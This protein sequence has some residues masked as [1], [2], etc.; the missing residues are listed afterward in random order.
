M[1]T[2][3]KSKPFLLRYDILSFIILYGILTPIIYNLIDI[4]FLYLKFI[5]VI[6]FFF[7]CIFYLIT[8]TNPKYKARNRYDQVK[9]IKLATHVKFV[10]KNKL[11]GEEVD[12]L[13]LKNLKIKLDN[14][15]TRR[16]VYFYRHKLRYYWKKEDKKFVKIKPFLK[17]KISNLIENKSKLYLD[18]VEE[19]LV[20][21]NNLVF[22]LPNFG[23][24]YKEQIMNPLNFFQLFSVALW[25]FD[26]N[27]YHPLM[28]LFLLLI[29]NST[30]CMQ[31]ISTILNLRSLQTKP[32]YVTIKCHETG[33]FK[34]ISSEN[35]KPGDIVVVKRSA[36]L[37]AVDNKYQSE[38]NLLN[39]LKKIV[40]FGSKLPPNLLLKFVPKAAEQKEIVNSSDLLILKGSVAVD[41]SILTGE[42][43]PQIKDPINQLFYNET[44]DKK[45]FK[46][47]II[48]AGTDIVQITPDKKNEEVLAK[49]LNTGFT[50]TKGKLARTVLFGEKTNTP[51]QYEAYLL[52]FI[53][54]IVSVFSSVYVLIQGLAEEDRN[55]DKLFIR[56]I[57]IVTSVVPP[58]LPMIMTMA[59]NNSLLYLKKKRIFCTE[60]HRINLAGKITTCV[61]DKTGT[62]TEEQLILKGVSLISNDGNSLKM[63]EDLRNNKFERF[64]DISMILGGCHSIVEINKKDVGDPVEMLFFENSDFKFNYSNK[65]TF[66][67]KNPNKYLKIRKTFYFNSTLKRM[68]SIIKVKEFDTKQEDYLVVKGAPEVIGDLLLNKPKNYDKFYFE[69]ANSGYRLLSLAMRPLKKNELNCDVRSEIEKDLIFAGFLVLTNDLKKDTKFYIENIVESGRDI[70]ILT[71]DHL[72]TSIQTYRSLEVSKKECLIITKKGENLIFTKIDGK[73][74]V[75]KNLDDYDLTVTGKYL[76]ELILEKPNLLKKLKVIARVNPKQKE[77]FIGKLKENEK[78]L[79]CGDGTNDVGALKKADVGIALVGKKPE[80]T[81]E[82]KL[83]RKK[84]KQEIMK[85]AIK[86]RKMYKMSD[87]NFDNDDLDFKLGDASIAAPFTNKHSNSLKCV[88]TVLKQGITTLNCG[89]QSYKIVTLTSLLSA[90]S[91]STLHLENLKFSDSQNTLM[92]LYGAYLYFT[93]SSGKPV[94]KLTKDKPQFSIFNRYFWLSLFGQ[95]FLQFAFL[96]MMMDFSKKYSPEGQEEVD[97]EDEFIPTFINSVMFLYEL[98]SMFCISIFNYEGRPFMKSLSENKKHFK[99]LILPVFLLFIFI[100]NMS[101]DICGFFELTYD[102]KNENSETFLF[103]MV[104]GF[105]GLSFAWTVFVKFLKIGRI[106]KFI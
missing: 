54:L 9:D 2:L 52:L 78:V 81:K 95:L 62:L 96:F 58:E 35:L 93:L 47:N 55:K 68:S 53:L 103:I 48:Y 74:I 43:L 72:L 33:Q 32:Y 88:I 49:V 97:N 75:P 20:D 89:I 41:E 106:E 11:K 39:E 57:L 102:S 3:L 50:T 92:G 14:S 59:I 29:T 71:G 44:F 13:E 84:K 1:I 5:L 80:P 82:L 77:I 7:N 17:Q 45:K 46:N 83:A 60:P 64:N 76:N 91:L 66:Y 51:S 34:K 104:F 38:D 16:V 100:F 37:E 36:E 67:V 31:R 86:E 19:K 18:E 94:K 63:E 24:I 8:E 87:L 23:Q 90:Y 40:P 79:M 69:L 98:S 6:T 56:C 99:F 12:V 30:V 28:M 27:F 73:E 25:F 4:E 105:I 65:Q 101:E 61:F 26:E 42:N 22:P 15:D 85:R 70:V 10:K 21:K